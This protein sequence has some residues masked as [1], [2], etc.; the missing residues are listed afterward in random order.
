VIIPTMSERES[1]ARR[2][3]Q[4]GA[5]EIVLPTS[6]PSGINKKVDVSE[7]A[8]KVRKV[9]S[10]PSYRENALWISARLKQ[11]GGAPNAAQLI[12]AYLAQNHVV[13]V[14]DNV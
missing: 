1:N 7:L 8:A 13:S 12:E 6:D 3:L 5:G 10:T 2:V 11:Y 4:Q 14:K 9:L